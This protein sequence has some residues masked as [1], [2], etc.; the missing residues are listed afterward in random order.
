MTE[1]QSP[2]SSFKPSNKNKPLREFPVVGA[3]EHIATSPQYAPFPPPQAS[4]NDFR[5]NYS[6]DPFDAP[7]PPSAE[8]LEALKRARQ[9]KLNPSVTHSARKRLEYL[10]DIGKITQDVEIGG[11]VFSLRTLKAKELREVYMAAAK[12]T[13]RIEELLIYRQYSLA[14]AINKLDQQDL[15]I[16]LDIKGLANRLKLVDDLEEST[17]AKLFEVYTAMK[18]QADTQ[19]SLKTETD[20]KE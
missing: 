2:P 17:I 15:E 11:S 18:N 4:P 7:A 8:E 16:M 19:F 14:Y 9:E 1:F 10:A 5:S 13:N 12:A 20:V 6:Q 3:E